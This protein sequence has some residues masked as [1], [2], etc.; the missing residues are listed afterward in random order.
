MTWVLVSMT[1]VKKAVKRMGNNIRRSFSDRA[2]LEVTKANF[3][4]IFVDRGRTNKQHIGLSQSG[5]MDEYAYLWANKLLGNEARDACIEISFG[6]F[7][8]KALQVCHVAITGADFRAE[9]NGQLLENWQTLKLKCGDELV[10]S[11]PKM[12]GTRAYLA[13]KGGFDCPKPFYSACTVLREGLGGYNSGAP[14]AVGDELA[15]SVIQETPVSVSISVS[16]QLIRHYCNHESISCRFIPAYQWSLFPSREQQRF[17][18][19]SF[20]ISSQSDRMGFR[21]EGERINSFNE[22]IISEGIALG[23]IQIPPDGQPIVLMRDR[24]TI[25]GYPKL[26]TVIS[27][28]IEK[29]AQAMPG[30]KLGF[31]ISDIE[32]AYRE[33]LQREQFFGM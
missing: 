18:Q 5:P 32:T 22:G 26:G 15:C 19:Q 31:Q 28:D 17:L 8:L 33:R 27:T 1:W 9:V 20:R 13:I 10:F 16:P 4:A 7:S 11:G 29:I 23:A 12:Q 25:G 2:V 14:L 6:Q 30:Q 21:L 3:S 24:Q